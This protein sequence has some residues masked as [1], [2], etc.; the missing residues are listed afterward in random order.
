M[1]SRSSNTAPRVALVLAAACW[2]LGAILSKAAL[3]HL[4]PLTLLV[5]Q[6]IASLA[7]LWPVL[8]WQRSVRRWNRRLLALGLLGLLNP[9]LSYTLSLIGLTLTTA[10]L[11]ALLWGLE[12]LLI[13]GLALLVLRERPTSRFLAL[14]GLAL[15]GALLAIGLGVDQPGRL[16]GTSLILAGVACCALYTVLAQRMGAGF[17]PLLTVTVQQSLALVGAV[18]TLLCGP[19]EL[20]R[21]TLAGLQQ[22]PAAAW[23]LAALSG[24]IYYGL[25]FWFYLG[26]L[27]RVSA[28]E[29]G[30]FINLVPIFALGGA[31]ALLGERLTPAQWAGCGLVLLA[32][33]GLSLGQKSGQSA[34]VPAPS[35]SEPD[36][37]VTTS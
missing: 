9:G 20:S 14:S 23:G 33:A 18:L 3:A 24:V 37:T 10:S 4:S 7:V 16:L 5:T 17:S 29:A 32:V 8:G 6:L 36:S 22:I 11:S 1:F 2:G 21:I 35:P 12:P 26:G 34:D 15:A 28:G 30:F 25:A 19:A 31:Y 27:Q 13:V